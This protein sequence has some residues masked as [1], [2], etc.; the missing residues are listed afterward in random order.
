MRH[1]MFKL[2]IVSYKIM[3]TDLIEQ[4]IVV[5]EVSYLK[6]EELSK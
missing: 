1:H 2:H 5:F 3:K 4:K 6:I